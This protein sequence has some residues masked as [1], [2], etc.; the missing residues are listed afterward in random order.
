M[1]AV[2]PYSKGGQ[3]LHP[4]QKRI[5]TVREYARA[6]GFPDKYEFLSASKHPSRQIEDQYRQIGNAVP[7]PLAL[8]LG[9]E[10]KKVLVDFWGEQ[11]R[12]SERTLSPEL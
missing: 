9:K 10:L 5:L 7:I 3:V 11:Y 1:T 2:V 4:N 12:S 8:A 6:Q